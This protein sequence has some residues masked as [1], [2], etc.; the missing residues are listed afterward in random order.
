MDVMRKELPDTMVAVRL[1]KMEI[2]DLT[3][4]LSDLGQEITK[5]LRSSTQAVRVAEDILHRLS[6]MH[7]SKRLACTSV[8][9]LAFLKGMELSRSKDWDRS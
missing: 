3:I 7:G 1:S 8:S 9:F 6:T 2:S 4:K 5:G